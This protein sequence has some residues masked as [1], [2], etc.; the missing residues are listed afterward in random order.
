MVI[1]VRLLNLFPALSQCGGS[2]QLEGELKET[3]MLHTRADNL[4]LKDPRLSHRCLMVNAY[5]TRT[6]GPCAVF[7]HT[8]LHSRC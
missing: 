7:S 3:V 4:L 2:G 8:F 5:S 1:Q 6:D